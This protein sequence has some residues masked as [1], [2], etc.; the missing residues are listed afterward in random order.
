MGNEYEIETIGEWDDDLTFE[1]QEAVSL[2][3]KEIVKIQDRAYLPKPPI[4]K[5]GIICGILALNDE[6]EVIV[7]FP[8][9][10]EQLCKTELCGDYILVEKACP[11]ES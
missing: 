4:D 11:T 1:L 5:I 10:L 9:G 3:Y 6:I 2:I 8:E 7:R